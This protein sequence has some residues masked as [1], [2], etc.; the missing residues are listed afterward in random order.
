MYLATSGLSCISVLCHVRSL[1][2]GHALTGLAAP[3]HVGPSFPNQGSNPQPPNWKADSQP[4]DHHLPILY[5]IVYIYQFR[6]PNLS[7][8]HLPSPLCNH[9]FVFYASES[10]S[11][12]CIHLFCILVQISH[13]VIQYL[14]FSVGLISLSRIFS[15][16]IYVA[17]NGT[18]SFF[19]WL[20]NIPLCEIFF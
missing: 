6:N 20:N 18:I 13:K 11:V 17:A 19:L 8:S 4:R 2:A 7:F 12:L 3:W 10:L 16:S 5:T 9:K 14:S 1:V 15:R